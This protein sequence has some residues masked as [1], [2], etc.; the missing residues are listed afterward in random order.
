MSRFGQLAKIRHHAVE[1]LQKELEEVNAE[2]RLKTEALTRLNDEFE[3]ADRPQEGT[4]REYAGHQITLRIYRRQMG[5]MGE[6]ILRLRQWAAQ[7][8]KRLKTALIEYEK[9]NH[10]DK[11]AQA[12][13]IALVKK[14]DT[15]RTEEAALNGYHLHHKGA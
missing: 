13:L 4:I 11:E 8:R 9:M 12:Q 14:L 10:L 1:A 3:N 7:I 6:E 15:Q 2:I 5:E